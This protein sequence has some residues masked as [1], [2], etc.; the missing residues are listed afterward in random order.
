MRI[1]VADDEKAVCSVLRYQIKKYKNPFLEIFEV[2]NGIQFKEKCLSWKPDLAFVDIKMPGLTGLEAITTIKEVEDDIN[3]TFI[4]LSGFNDF[5]YAREALRLE[6]K[7]YL[8]KPSKIEMVHKIIH[9]IELKRYKGLSLTNLEDSSNCEEKQ[10]I[11]L[12]QK[13]QELAINF[14]LENI[15]LFTTSLDQWFISA[16]LLKISID[17]SFFLT[18]FSLEYNDDLLKQKSIIIEESNKWYNN[19]SSAKFPFDLKKYVDN[20]FID[21]SFN[22]DLMSSHFGFSP[23]YLSL[24]FKN[25]IGENF[26]VYLT[27]KRLNKAKDLLLNT[28]MLIKNI[29]LEC[30]YSYTSYFIKIFNKNEKITPNEFRNKY[31]L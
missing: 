28:P 5:E 12:S 18:H 15:Q 13:L 27:R 22:L 10:I 24:I 17:E 21:P 4:M 20:N 9:G 16:N 19:Q 7:D 30:G 31:R 1:L 3:T 14:K 8:L 11:E 29:S 25:E 26:I 23:Q 2:S 6:V